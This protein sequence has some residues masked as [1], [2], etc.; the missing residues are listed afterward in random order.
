MLNYY[1]YLESIRRSIHSTNLIERIN[2]EI[3]RR[4]K[5][6][7]SLPWE[8]STMKIISLR[9]TKTNE[10]WSLRSLRFYKCKDEIMEMYL[11]RHLI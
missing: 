7:D 3:Q 11:T 4:I 5:I 2:K 1:D 6:I 10:K 9:A 8:E